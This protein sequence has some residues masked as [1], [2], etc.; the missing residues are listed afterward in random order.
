MTQERMDLLNQ[1]DFS[2]EVRPTLDRPRAS[3]QHRLE[4]LRAYAER[5]GGSLQV[6]AEEMPNLYAWCIEQRQRLQWYDKH[7][8]DDRRI[9]PDRV[10][11][12]HAIGFTKDI[13]LSGRHDSGSGRNEE[14]PSVATQ[15][16]PGKGVANGAAPPAVM[17]AAGEFVDT[18][19]GSTDLGGSVA[20]RSLEAT[21][22]ESSRLDGPG[23]D[24]ATEVGNYDLL[25]QQQQQQQQQQEGQ[26]QQE[27]EQY[28]EQDMPP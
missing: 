1:L 7:N 17:D 12:L 15:S 16:S 8:G 22:E 25:Q 13:V 14:D 6:D 19:M 10:Q 18:V 28:E 21:D 9:S 11:A 27:L 5:T 4:E 23:R 24:L 26:Q 2:W 3:W 20:G